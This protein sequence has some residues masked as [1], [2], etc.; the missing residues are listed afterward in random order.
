MRRKTTALPIV[1]PFSADPV[2]TGL[3]KS[4]AHPGTHVTGMSALGPA[5]PLR[6]GRVIE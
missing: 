2:A 3:V 4:L 6:A 5:I 1:P